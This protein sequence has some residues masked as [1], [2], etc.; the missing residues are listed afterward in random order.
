LKV[1]RRVDSMVVKKNVW[2]VQSERFFKVDII[3][4][5]QKCSSISIFTNPSMQA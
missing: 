4:I 1:T 3:Q 2:S 5:P